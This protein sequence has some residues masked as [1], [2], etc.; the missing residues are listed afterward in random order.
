MKRGNAFEHSQISAE[1]ET[2]QEDG[3][4]V[5]ELVPEGC[6]QLCSERCRLDLDV[7]V[8]VVECISEKDVVLIDP[9]LELVV[10]A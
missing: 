2:L 5:C 9:F 8:V 3:I 1:V 7:H 6:T 10:S 4:E